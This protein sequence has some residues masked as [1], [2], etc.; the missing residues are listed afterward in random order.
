MLKRFL[1]LALSLAVFGS[2]SYVLAQ[3]KSKPFI[4]TA[5]P[6][7][8]T[9]RLQKRFGKVAQYLSDTLGVTVNYIPVK[10]YSASV[11]AFKNNEVQLAWFGG[12]SGVQA[13]FA[14]PGATA[15]AQGEEDPDFITYFIAH[16]STGLTPSAGFPHGIEDM[17]FTFGSKGSTSGR[18]MP[19]F[20]I[21]AALGKTPREA[22]RRVG[23][24]GD[25][26]KTL[27]L[28]QSGSYQVGALNY[29]VWENEVKAGKVDESKVQVIWRTPG[30]PDYNWTIRGDVD[31]TWGEGFI[32][33]V[34]QALLDMNDPELL[35]SFPR[36]RFIKA[37][38]SMYQ[39]ILDTAREIGIL[40]K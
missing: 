30:Y 26:S 27:A 33:K 34:Q 7:Q 14:V 17:T 18:L 29:K 21:R 2:T 16:T 10:S 24:S 22:F 1:I 28:V 15:I 31:E 38:N 11:A 8:D 13:R 20:F 23:F 32:G 35:A 5:I 37:D 25:H 39:P 4:F 36:K 3:D 40:Q 12:L 19:E 9:T 6:D